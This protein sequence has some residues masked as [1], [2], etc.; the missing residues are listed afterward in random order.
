MDA[1][2]EVIDKTGFITINQRKSAGSTISRSGHLKTSV[3]QGGLYRFTVGA[4][5]GLTYSTNRELLTGLDV[6]DVTVSSNVSIGNDGTQK[7]DYITKYQGG[8]TNSSYGINGLTLNGFS[9]STLYID[10]TNISAGS[11]T[12]FKVGDFLQPHGNTQTYKYPYQVTT[13][14]A[15]STSSNVHVQ[16]NRPIIDQPGV[17]LTSGGLRLGRE[18]YFNLTCLQNPTYSVVP[19]DLIEFT[20]DFELMET[21]I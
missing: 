20:G 15:Y 3:Q 8:I 14:V 21:I 16:V 4:P 10:A 5:Q 7:L 19:Y 17:S 1:L 11:G 18:V 6:L 9:G 2:Q 13:E 12:M